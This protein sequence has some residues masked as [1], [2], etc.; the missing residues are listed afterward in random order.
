MGD[1]WS[2][3][4]AHSF[5]FWKLCKLQDF[6]QHSLV[7]VAHSNAGARD[8]GPDS[9]QPGIGTRRNGWLDPVAYSENADD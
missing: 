3:V 7:K 1:C 8:Y 9:F 5:R 4:H 2:R 6:W